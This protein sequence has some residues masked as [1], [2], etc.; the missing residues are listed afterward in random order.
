LKSL[1][2]SNRFADTPSFSLL[3]PVGKKKTE[4]SVCQRSMLPNS[5]RP[6]RRNA[7]SSRPRPP[8]SHLQRKKLQ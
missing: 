5:S 7:R 6:L 1:T 4:L 2:G 8:P 3:A